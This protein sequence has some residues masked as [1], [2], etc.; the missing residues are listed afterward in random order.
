MPAARPHRILR[1]I[2]IQLTMVFCALCPSLADAQ[3]SE[4]RWNQGEPAGLVDGVPTTVK[5]AILTKGWPTRRGSRTISAEGP[6]EEDAPCVA[7]LREQGAVLIGKT[8]APEFS[9]KSV[10]NSPLYGITR[11]PW[12][13]DLTPGGSSGGAAAAAAAGLG[14]LHIGGD[15]AGSVRNP[16]ALCGVYGIKPD[17]ATIA[18]YPH[19]SAGSAGAIGPLTRSVADLALAL[20]VMAGADWRDWWAAPPTGIEYRA[21]LDDGIA[22]MRIAYSRNLGYA[23]VLPE[24]EALVTKAADVL[25]ERG[26]AVEE[27]DPGFANPNEPFD[28]IYAARYGD[29]VERMSEARRALLDPSLIGVWERSQRVTTADLIEAEGARVALGQVMARFHQQ[30][31]VLVTPQLPIPAF[32]ANSEYPASLG[33][34]PDEDW[35]VFSYPFNFSMQP[36][37]S[38]NV[39][40]TAAGLPVSAQVVGPRYREDV[41]L[42]VAQVLQRAYPFTPPLALDA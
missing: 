15:G 36:A 20:T 6:W 19:S 31:D 35:K 25:A 14:A 42:R 11:N 16:A 3:A 38:V 7:R 37:L 26:A 30:F 5:D 29:V 18:F 39:G 13:T 8:T 4:R 33:Y 21:G 32:E 12:N 34:G 40:H 23:R 41:I 27:R 17:S 9:H 22:G 10:T 24:I 2:A 28:A 1:S